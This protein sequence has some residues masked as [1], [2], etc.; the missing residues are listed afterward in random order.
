MM[1]PSVKQHWRMKTC[2][3]VSALAQE[4]GV[5]R[6]QLYRFRNEALGRAPVLGPK[7]WLREK[8]D[9]RR[10]ILL[11]IRRIASEKNR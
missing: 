3:D 5:N 4:L 9:Q 2:Q 8:S 11:Y 1:S 10:P 7:S 6:S